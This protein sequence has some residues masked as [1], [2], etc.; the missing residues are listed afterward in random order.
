MNRKPFFVFVCKQ[1]K[2]SQKLFEMIQ[3]S[4]FRS[5][6][7]LANLNFVFWNVARIEI[8]KMNYA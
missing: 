3:V 7:E 8:E 6:H 2:L 4:G 1:K 5:S